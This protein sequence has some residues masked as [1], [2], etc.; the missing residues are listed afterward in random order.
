MGVGSYGS[1]ITIIGGYRW[2]TQTTTRA[3]TRTTRTAPIKREYV[4]K[5]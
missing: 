2:A 1:V 4:V 5:L 3:D